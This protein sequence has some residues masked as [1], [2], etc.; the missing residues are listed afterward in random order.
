MTT[1]AEIEPHS[2]GVRLRRVRTLM[3]I[4]IPS[5]G[6]R[7]LVRAEQYG[8]IAWNGP[9]HSTE[10]IF[11]PQDKTFA[12]IS[13]EMMAWNISSFI[14]HREI[15]RTPPQESSYVFIRDRAAVKRFSEAKP[16]GIGALESLR[17]FGENGHFSEENLPIVRRLIAAWA[18]G[19]PDVPE[20]ELLTLGKAT[21][22]DELWADKLVLGATVVTI[23][24]NESLQ[25]LVVPGSTPG[26]WRI[27]EP[28]AGAVVDTVPTPP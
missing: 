16:R 7:V 2:G 11:V 9:F 26:T 10:G 1:A 8:E 12:T 22:L 25:N 28:P 6:M 19:Q 23:P 18:D 20:A 15:D 3:K 24:P 4:E 13:D 27:K 14:D 21:T 17:W 5:S